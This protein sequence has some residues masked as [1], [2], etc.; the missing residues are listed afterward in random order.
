MLSD[1]VGRMYNESAAAAV[2]ANS[3]SNSNRLERCRQSEP[4]KSLFTCLYLSFYFYVAAAAAYLD[5]TVY[6]K[7]INCGLNSVNRKGL[8]GLAHTCAHL[9]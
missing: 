1:A 9:L 4:S 2:M 6:V 5:L 8:L 3:N 7:L